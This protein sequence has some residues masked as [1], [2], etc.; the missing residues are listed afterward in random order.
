MD[1]CDEHQRQALSFLRNIPIG[2]NSLQLHAQPSAESSTVSSIPDL[3]L[4]RSQEEDS[5]NEL[6]LHYQEAE[7]SQE[8]FGTDSNYLDLSKSLRRRI[9]LKAKKCVLGRLSVHHFPIGVITI[10]VTQ[11]TT[12]EKTQKA[13]QKIGPPYLASVFTPLR[14]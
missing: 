7:L 14:G 10:A 12:M 4:R 11:I 6:G 2:G 9:P 5:Q 3:P 13:H 8:L 1:G